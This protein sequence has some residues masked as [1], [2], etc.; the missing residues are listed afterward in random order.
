MSC[1]LSLV[2]CC[3]WLLIAIFNVGDSRARTLGSKDNYEDDT[4]ALHRV[5][6][7]FQD[8]NAPSINEIQAAY[9]GYVNL[10]KIQARL[11]SSYDGESN[12]E[13]EYENVGNILNLP[14]LKMVQ[15]NL[16]TVLQ[17]LDDDATGEVKMDKQT[18]QQLQMAI[19]GLGLKR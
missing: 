14:I 4:R 16:F 15:E 13:K 1:K 6:D 5:I 3:V 2:V 17:V 10:Y 11:A 19:D 12:S 18:I 7:L 9:K 8:G